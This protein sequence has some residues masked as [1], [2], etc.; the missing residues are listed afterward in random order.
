MNKHVGDPRSRRG[1]QLQWRSPKVTWAFGSSGFLGTLF[2]GMLAGCRGMRD[3]EELSEELDVRDTDGRPVD[4]ISDTTLGTVAAEIN[5]DDFEQPLVQQVRDM[6]RRKELRPVGLP[7]GV[8]TVDGKALGKLKHDAK[9][10]ALKQ[11]DSNGK[12]FWYVRVLRAVLSSA[13]GKPCIGQRT[14]PG[15]EGEITNFPDFATWLHET[16]GVHEYF[17]IFDGCST[18][19]ILGRSRVRPAVAARGVLCVA[20]LA[21]CDRV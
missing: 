4:K 2:A 3:V 17:G 10:H 21:A 19:E 18:S 9:G 1:R 5:P 8:A 16:Y 11:T 13:A 14:I 15:R 20:C 6:N 7:C 12:D